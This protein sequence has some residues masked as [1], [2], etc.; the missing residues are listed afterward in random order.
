MTGMQQTAAHVDEPDAETLA[1]RSLMLSENDEKVEQDP[2][3]NWRRAQVQQTPRRPISTP[4]VSEITSGKLRPQMRAQASRL[5]SRVRGAVR[6]YEPDRKVI[7]RTSAILLVL[8][9][10]ALVFGTLFLGVFA[11]LLSYLFAGPER[12]WRAVVSLYRA[13]ARKRPQ[14]A[15]ILKL[16]AY[17]I[18]KKWNRVLSW[19]PQGVA[20]ALRVP[21][22]T[23]MLAADARHE[24]AMTLRLNRLQQDA[25]HQDGLSGFDVLNSGACRVTSTGSG[26][27]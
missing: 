9:K 13:Y 25:P 24:S 27:R 16:R 22:V 20:D 21:D 17:K 7:I 2:S 1:V 23:A 18:A 15:R 19:A 4:V 3:G 5:A 12:F 26:N 10:P 6:N 14:A 8:L 11:L